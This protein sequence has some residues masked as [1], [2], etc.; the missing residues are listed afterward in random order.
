MCPHFNDREQDF[1]SS[2]LANNI[3]EA[4]CIENDCAVEFV[5]G[6]FS[7]VISAGGQA[8]TLKNIKGNIN[9]RKL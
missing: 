7:K 1:T 3:S 2:M 8:Y 9:K 4:L 5:N 6:E